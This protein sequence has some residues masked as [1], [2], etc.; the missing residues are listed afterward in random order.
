MKAY[1]WIFWASLG[2]TLGLCIALF[3]FN[4]LAKKVPI[5]YITLFIFTVMSAYVLASICTFQDP[6]NVM[7]A[8]ALTMAVFISL[9][10]LTFFVTYCN[11]PL[12]FN[13]LD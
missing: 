5:N 13:H 8:A 9:T 6:I 10:T 7:I 2:I 11:I 3:C 12:K 4:T 1:R